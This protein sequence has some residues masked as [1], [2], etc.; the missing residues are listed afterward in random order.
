MIGRDRY[1]QEPNQSRDGFDR[2]GHIFDRYGYFKRYDYDRYKTGDQERAFDSQRSAYRSLTG[3]DRSHFETRPM[4]DR[5]DRNEQTTNRVRFDSESR[6]KQDLRRTSISDVGEALTPRRVS[7]NF[8]GDS[9]RARSV[10]SREAV[11]DYKEKDRTMSRERISTSRPETPSRSEKSSIRGDRESISNEYFIGSSREDEAQ[12]RP[13]KQLDR[14]SFEREERRPSVKSERRASIQKTNEDQSIIIEKRPSIKD[15]RQSLNQNDTMTNH[16]EV[17]KQ[18]VDENIRIE[19]SRSDS[20]VKQDDF[21]KLG[22]R[23]ESFKEERRASVTEERRASVTEERRGSIRE[24]RM[25]SI[26]GERRGPLK[27]ERESVKEERRGSVREERRNSVKEEGRAS[28]KDE[29]IIFDKENRKPSV[30]E[31]RRG[32]V[33]K[34]RRG[35]LRDE[36]KG[37]SVK[38][39]KRESSVETMES[40]VRDERR[41]SS[42]RDERNGSFLREERRESS[43]ERK[44][45]SVRDERKASLVRDERKGSFLRDERKGSFIRDER[46]EGSLERKASSVRD[47][48]KASSVRDERKVSLVRDERKGRSERDERKGSVR[49]DRKG[50]VRDERKFSMKSERKASVKDERKGSVKEERRESFKEGRRSSVKD[51]RQPSVKDERRCSSVDA[52][53]KSETSHLPIDDE[54]NGIDILGRT[55]ESEVASMTEKIRFLTKSIENRMPPPIPPFSEP[56]SYYPTKKIC[57]EDS[58]NIYSQ[59]M[60]MRATYDLMRRRF[61]ENASDPSQNPIWLQRGGLMNVKDL[62]Q[63]MERLLHVDSVDFMAK[64]NAKKHRTFEY[65]LI[66]DNEQPSP[67]YRRGQTFQMNVTFRDRMLDQNL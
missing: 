20:F 7:G 32:S 27:D 30:K 44:P 15:E 62:S 63:K 13:S 23:K 9:R 67:I 49:E 4:T 1:A 64:E 12:R 25:G 50:S 39:E 58:S 43:V 47:E 21:M 6:S 40:S 19:C 60:A 42:V 41:P 22:E 3:L 61:Y 5:S 33:Q 16:F 24:E 59:D 54:L 17:E 18:G 14:K 35:S 11:V 65:E 48:R 45:S 55:V 26:K 52:R 10:D 57:N 51:E 37:S 66:K 2:Y 53:R 28:I 34:E 29:R 8:E 36:R 38:E 31:E 56:R 46:I